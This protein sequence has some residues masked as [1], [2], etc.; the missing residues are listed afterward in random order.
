MNSS[1][2][3]KLL[4]GLFG[5]IFLGSVFFLIFEGGSQEEVAAKEKD[6]KKAAKV[7]SKGP[8]GE[9]RKLCPDCGKELPS[10]G[11]CPYCLLQKREKSGGKAQ[12]AEPTSRLGRYLAWSLVGFTVLLGAV[13]LALIARQRRR[14]LR[15]EEDEQLKTKC[16]Y[17]KRRVRF[18]A[19]LAGTS[20]SCPTCKKRI[21]FKP[22]ADPY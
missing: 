1:S 10:G 12:T 9:E 7:K 2:R 5:L 13:H 3:A 19:H 18:P 8:P 15:S 4:A 11:E 17:C 16:P 21:P 20:G 22:I 14:D 6:L